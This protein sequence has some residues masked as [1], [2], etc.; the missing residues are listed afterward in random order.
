MEDFT[1]EINKATKLKDEGNSFF[2]S[3]KFEDAKNTYINARQVI[4]KYHI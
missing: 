3:Q 4:Q 2:K 1:P